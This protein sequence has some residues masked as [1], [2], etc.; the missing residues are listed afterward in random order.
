MVCVCVWVDG[1]MYVCVCVCV[2]V[3]VCVCVCARAR[4][5]ACLRGKV[6]V[7]GVITISST[8]MPSFYAITNKKTARLRSIV[9]GLHLRLLVVA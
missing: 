4:A 1:C 6:H 9:L 5:R 3:C 8:M 7:C 2:I